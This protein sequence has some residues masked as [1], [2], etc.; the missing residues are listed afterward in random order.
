MTI[1]HTFRRKVHVTPPSFLGAVPIHEVY[2]GV[3]K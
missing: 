3:C 1:P 2:E